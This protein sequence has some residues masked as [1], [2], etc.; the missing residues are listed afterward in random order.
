MNNKNKIF[1]QPKE[2]VSK[3]P[4]KFPPSVPQDD[5]FS[6]SNS[7]LFNS[8]EIFGENFKSL[9]ISHFPM[10]AKNDDSFRYIEKVQRNY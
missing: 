7:E 3:P 10:I 4:V 5:S 9:D 1:I 8:S 2:E 6:H